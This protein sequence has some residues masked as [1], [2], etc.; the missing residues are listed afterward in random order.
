MKGRVSEVGLIYG[1]FGT[2][3]LLTL[4]K[5]YSVYTDYTNKSPGSGFDQGKKLND[6]KI[7]DIVL[8]CPY[9]N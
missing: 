4:W 8:S 5:I 7:L 3:C 2:V 9:S 1:Y 6:I